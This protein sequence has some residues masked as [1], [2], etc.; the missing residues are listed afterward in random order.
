MPISYHIE[1]DAGRVVL[2]FRGTI[3]DREL[4]ATYEALYADPSHRVGLDELTDCREV[5]RVDVTTGALVALAASTA[6]LLDGKQ[7]T[8]RVAIVAPSD[9][10]F[11]MARMYE[12]FRAESPEQVQV[13]R[14]RAAAEAWLAD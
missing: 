2:E 14:D 3:T 10:V 9:V 12:A 8:W 11:G 7:Q 1:K 6:R 4:F 5:E 13:F